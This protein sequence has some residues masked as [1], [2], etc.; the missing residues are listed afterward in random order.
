MLSLCPGGP[1]AGGPPGGDALP[2]TG[3]FGGMWGGGGAMAAGTWLVGGGPGGTDSC[4]V[5][6]CTGG[7]TKYGALPFTPPSGGYDELTK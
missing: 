5:V 4:V 7:G 1:T 2:L 3:T 6:E